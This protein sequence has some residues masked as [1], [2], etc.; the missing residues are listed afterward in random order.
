MHMDQRTLDR[1]FARFEAFKN[2][3]PSS[4]AEDCVE[5]Y[6]ALVDTLSAAT[7]QT[8]D[9]FK[10]GDAEL[11][12]EITSVQRRSF[13]GRPGH[14]TYSDKRYCDSDRFKR[15]I[16]GLSHYLESQGYL[17]ATTTSARPP[18][19]R[20]THSV[21]VEHMYGSAI[22]QGGSH[23]PIKIHFDAKNADFKTLIQNMKSK[24]PSLGLDQQ[25]TAQLVSDAA[26]IQA[27]IASPLPKPSVITECLSS[28]RAILENVAGN[29]LA[30]GL[31]HE[32]TKY[33]S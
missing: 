24:A 6:H 7:G 32:I 13:S 12:K 21:H 3:L 29:A 14:V 10:I 30:A 23:S 15:Q 1:I 26:T 11:K 18:Q 9:D 2:N 20:A 31:I 5:E 27:Q 19:P 25:S 17:T 8:L 33:L 28:A 4:I 16:D 22:Q